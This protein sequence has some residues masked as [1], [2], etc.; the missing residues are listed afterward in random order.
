MKKKVKNPY[1]TLKI[2]K[3]IAPNKPKNEP[4]AKRIVGGDLRA[5]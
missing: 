3:T 5:K 4:K 1:A 2:D